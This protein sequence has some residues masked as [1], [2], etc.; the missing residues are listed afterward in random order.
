LRQKVKILLHI[1]QSKTGT[2]AI[3][4]YLTLNKQQLLKHGILYPKA[5]RWG[6]PLDLGSHN[7]VADSLVG[8]SRYPHLSSEKYFKYFFKEAKKTKSHLMILSAE[9][10]FGGEPRVWDTSDKK[11][12]DEKYCKKIER[13]TH[14]LSGHE[15]TVLIYLRPQADWLASAINQTIRIERLISKKR[16]YHD[17]QHFFDLVKP[18][19]DYYG[20][21]T[22]W[23]EILKPKNFIA[24]PYE[25]T[26]LV[27]GSS[28]SDFFYRIGFSELKLPSAHTGVEVNRSVTREFIEVKK[29]LNQSHNSKCEERVIIRCLETLSSKSKFQ[30]SYCLQ[31]NLI[32]SIKEFV[33]D[34]NNKINEEFIIDG[35][36]LEH[37]SKSLLDN[38]PDKITEEQLEKA[39][40][41]FNQERGRTQ[42]NLLFIEFK[43]LSW[44]RKYCKP[45]HALL[46]QIKRLFRFVR[47]MR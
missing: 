27:G 23:K 10:F 47:Y 28:I 12:F 17:D 15:V 42:A 41:D 11:I 6:L 32:R 30:T 22:L 2:S 7:S 37:A 8:V 35:H 44:I 21:L 31:K 45:L 36:C 3:Q 18:L 9:H 20:K 33:A 4:A 29:R 5:S 34:G 38:T 40:I 39:L 16:I 24:V 19:L 1:G 14:F 43:L 25:R 46:H 13:L 26:S